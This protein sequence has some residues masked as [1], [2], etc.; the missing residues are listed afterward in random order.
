VRILFTGA[1]SFTGT[2]FA[3]ELAR[4]GHEVCA[5]FQR[6]AADYA[7]VRDERVGRL[8]S[9]C[10]RVFECSFGDSKFLELIA[11]EG[12]WDALC[13]H[14]ADVTDYKSLDFDVVRALQNNTKNLPGVLEALHGKGCRR[15]VLTGS[16]FEGGEGAGSGDLCA[17]S[18]Y[19]L[20]KELTARVFHYRVLGAGMHLGKFVIPNPFGPLEEPRFTAYLMRTWFKGDC[21]AVNTPAYVRDNIH[22]SLLARAYA[23]FASELPEEAGFS[24]L[25]PRGYVSTQ[26][27]FAR[28]FAR[29]MEER[30]DIKCA[31]DLKEQTQFDEPRERFNTDE[32]DPA[33][34]DWDESA[35]W[36]E[37]AEYYSRVLG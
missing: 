32:V 1:S 12:R 22:V 31:L 10:T 20:S 4:A 25:N 9:E 34:L 35:A 37:L 16:V 8:A 19:G 15:V 7:G 30:L 36:D 17:F 5:V 27:E 3:S 23:R 6:K 21:A 29:A 11:G 24:R 14:A 33:A 28:R 2:W 13:H 26:G 18:P